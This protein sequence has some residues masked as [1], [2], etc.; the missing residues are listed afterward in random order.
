[1]ENDEIRPACSRF[2]LRAPGAPSAGRR[3]A[4]GADVVRC[5]V[6]WCGVCRICD[7]F[8]ARAGKGRAGKGR[9]G[10]PNTLC[11]GGRRSHVAAKSRCE[12][13]SGSLAEGMLARRDS[14]LA[15]RCAYDSIDPAL[16]VRR[17]DGASIR[18]GINR[19]VRDS[20]DREPA[21]SI[22]EFLF[23]GSRAGGRRKSRS[24]SRG[25]A[26][27]AQWMRDGTIE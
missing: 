2:A 4:R 22:L 23:D 27:S 16:A 13:G 15:A 17:R 3:P 24:R 19:I 20:F 7:G 5:G 10:R 26:C 14:W 21:A 12:R 11:D 18:G 8:E 9:E 25:A 1:V 6:G